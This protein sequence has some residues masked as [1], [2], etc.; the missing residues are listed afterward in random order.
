MIDKQRVYILFVLCMAWNHATGQNLVFN[1]SFEQYSGCP[2]DTTQN[3]IYLADGWMRCNQGTSDFFTPCA[4]NIFQV[5]NNLSGFQYAYNGQNYAGVAISSKKIAFANYYENIKTKLV[6]PLKKEKYVISLF[7]SLA[8][9][10]QYYVDTL[11]IYFSKSSFY[12]SSIALVSYD[13]IINVVHF[14]LPNM[15]NTTEWI[16]LCDTFTA[17]GGEQYMII[18]NFDT[19]T[20]YH[21]FNPG[22][23]YTGTYFYIDN[24]SLS[25]YREDLITDTAVIACRDSV[26]LTAGG[27][28]SY[29]W[30]YVYNG[31]TYQFSGPSLTLVKPI[32]PAYVT[33]TGNSCFS[34]ITD[35]VRIYPC[36]DTTGV[37]LFNPTNHTPYAIS[38][39]FSYDDRAVYDVQA[40]DARGRIVWEQKE[41]LP[42]Q[43]YELPP[44]LA[45]A[46]YIFRFSKNQQP[47]F[48]KKYALIY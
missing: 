26:T 37:I 12:D 27:S 38:F 45:D 32:L 9:K 14:P 31:F 6:I 47:F 11:S 15:P 2:K 5:P 40:F 34:S 35:T 3:G 4:E 19:N 16:E 17:V 30:E 8:D 43:P 21:L 22:G 39:S 13:S 10:V 41:I 18:S 1:G 44:W 7:I 36:Q 29:Q 48:S 42:L 25:E 33:V 28:V 20:V 24:I 23:T 46:V